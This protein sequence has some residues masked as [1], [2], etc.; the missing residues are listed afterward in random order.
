MPFQMTRLDDFTCE[1]IRSGF[2]SEV[3]KVS[4]A[5]VFSLILVEGQFHCRVHSCVSLGSR[6]CLVRGLWILSSIVNSS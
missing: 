4:D 6:L 1:K 3:F 2:F 5:T